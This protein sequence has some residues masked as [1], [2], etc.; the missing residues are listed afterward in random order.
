RFSRDWSSDVCSSDL[1]V[2]DE[3]SASLFVGY[4]AAAWHLR[5]QLDAEGIR[6]DAEHPLFVYLP[7]GVGGAPGGIAYGLRQIFGPHVHCFF[8]EPTQSPC[9]L[10]RMMAGCGQLPPLAGPPSVYGLGLR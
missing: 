3:R 9:F 1:F 6:V 4:A 2:D 8:A 5:T 10:A 7:C